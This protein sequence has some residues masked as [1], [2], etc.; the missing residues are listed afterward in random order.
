MLICLVSAKQKRENNIVL[1]FKLFFRIQLQ[2]R[3]C[4]QLGVWHE[5]LA[6]RLSTAAPRDQVHRPN[7]CATDATSASSGGG[8][9][10]SYQDT[11]TNCVLLVADLKSIRILLVGLL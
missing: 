9:L 8:S 6:P 1:F 5:P 2:I 7:D 10:P 11:S 4:R 3:T